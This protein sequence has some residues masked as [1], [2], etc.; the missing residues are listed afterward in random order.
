[1]I[2]LIYLWV[3]FVSAISFME[4]WLKFKAEGVTRLIGLSIGREVFFTLN[5]VEIVFAMLI[6]IL[7]LLLVRAKKHRHSLLILGIP[8]FIVS[9]QTICLLPILDERA[10]CIIANK[11]VAPSY[12]HM[13]YV[14]TEIIKVMSLLWTGNKIFNVTIK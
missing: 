11:T 12:I 5:K 9:L 2:A 1:M 6:G 3:G 14:L 4:A 10:G 8:M 7:W 13:V